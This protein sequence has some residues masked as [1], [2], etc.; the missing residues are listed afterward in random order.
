MFLNLGGTATRGNTDD[1]RWTLP[2]LV[3]GANQR[4]GS[5]TRSLIV[6]NDTTTEGG[7]TIVVSGDDSTHRSHVVPAVILL[8]DDDLPVINLT[9]DKNTIDEDDGGTATD[10]VVTA[11]F[12]DGMTRDSDVAV[13]L[14]FGGSA[15]G[16]GTDYSVAGMTTITIPTGDTSKTLTISLTPIDD[17]DDDND[18]TIIIQGANSGY[19]VNPATVTITDNDGPSTK[20]ILSVT[21]ATLTE[22]GGVQ[23]V[24]VKAKL[25]GA[26]RSSDVRVTLRLSGNAGSGDYSAPA[27][28]ADQMHDI[29]IT[30]D[31]TETTKDFEF[32]P[33]PDDIDEGDETI[34]VGGSAT[35][36]L[37]LDSADI[38]ITDDPADTASTTIVL[39]ADVASISEDSS[40]DAVVTVK[41]TL[42]GTV[43]RS[44]ATVVD[45]DDALAGTATSTHYR[46]LGSLPGSITIP[47]ESL[48]ADATTTF[49]IRAID[50]NQTQGDKTITLGGTATGFSVTALEITFADDDSPSTSLT[51]TVDANSQRA[52]DQTTVDENIAGDADGNVSVTVKATLD[53]G[54]RAEAVTVTFSALGGTAGSSDYAIDPASLGTLTIP[55]GESSA[56]KTFKFDPDNDTFDESDGSDARPHETVVINATASAAT[57]SPTAIDVTAATL[58]IVDDDTAS[59]AIS[60][61]VDTDAVMDDNQ[62]SIGE[63]DSETAVKVTA[64]LSGSGTYE[65]DRTVAVQVVASPSG[66]ATPSADATSGD[67]RLKN[68]ADSSVSNVT[69]PISLGNITIPAGSLEQSATFKVTP[70]DDTDSEGI[71]TIRVDGS[72]TGFTVAH[73]DI[74]LVDNDDPVINLQLDVTSAREDVTSQVVR[75]SATRDSSEATNAAAVS[76]TIG[77]DGSGSTATRGGSSA[78]GDYTAITSTTLSFR[79]GQTTSNARIVLFVIHDDQLTEGNET[80]VF[81]GSATGFSV[82][83]ATFTIVDDDDDASDERDHHRL[84]RPAVPRAPPTRRSQ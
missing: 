79:A 46:L 15:T 3:I 19:R 41:A 4:T 77:A 20:V 78:G 43:S 26:V 50:N 58:T 62:N 10:V 39:S 73:S 59:T 61:V 57:T 44:V 32:T 83:P 1:Y 23:T 65:T 53:G 68:F 55:I 66:G 30:Q 31:T 82:L 34:T 8:T 84:A 48:S 38:T 11:A 37:S 56:S 49:R 71:E 80:V 28:L 22:N 6:Q 35:G 52:G 40:T 63:G 45:L 74:N 2:D 21:P 12:A 13:T 27:A 5:V 51:L 81:A 69:L 9:V 25:D 17:D 33:T 24:T 14:S 47:A 36:G 75:V 64:R 70:R 7:E 42:Q 60:L 29:T 67:Y 18:E 72:L 76:V 16:G 54:T